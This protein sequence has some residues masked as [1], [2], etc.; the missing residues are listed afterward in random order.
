MF[1]VNK[2]KGEKPQVL[3]TDFISRGYEDRQIDMQISIGRQISIDGY[4]DIYRQIDRDRYADIFSA[5][6]W[7]FIT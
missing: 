3:F 2:E 5:N 1:M 4:A 6:Y 7:L